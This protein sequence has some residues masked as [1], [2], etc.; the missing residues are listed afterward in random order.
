MAGRTG[1]ARPRS[2]WMRAVTLP[3]SFAGPVKSMPSDAARS[4]T[5]QA[6]ST[7]GTNVCAEAMYPGEVVPSHTA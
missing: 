5:R 3:S 1:K 2:W 6:S 4:A 7:P